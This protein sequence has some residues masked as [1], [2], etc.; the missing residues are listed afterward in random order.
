MGGRWPENAIKGIPIQSIPGD[1]LF[2]FAHSCGR[3]SPCPAP[4]INAASWNF[5]HQLPWRRRPRPRL[6]YMI[7]TAIKVIAPPP[8]FNTWVKTNYY[9]LGAARSEGRQIK[10]YV[11]ET[12]HHS[13]GSGGCGWVEYTSE[14]NNNNNN[15]IQGRTS[16]C[17]SHVCNGS[18][19][20]HNRQTSHI[21]PLWLLLWGSVE[22]LEG[23]APWNLLLLFSS[24]V[25]KI[26]IM[27][28]G[29]PEGIDKSIPFR[30]FNGIQ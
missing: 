17:I 7:G 10:E 28:Q 5:Y 4:L 11:Q 25:L 30:F 16:I 15:V 22:F 29:I 19:A 1:R 24:V 27:I 3:L 18:W 14:T 13:N 6:Y 21:N 9:T 20:T 8:P 26:W 23:D 12:Q 2:W